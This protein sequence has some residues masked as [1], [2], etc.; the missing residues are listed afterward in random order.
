[1]VC[2][3]LL[4]GLSLNVTVPSFMETSRRFDSATR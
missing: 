3:G 2:Q 4:C 1:M